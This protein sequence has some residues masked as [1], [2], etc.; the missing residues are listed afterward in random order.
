MATSNSYNFTVDRDDLITDALMYI[1]AIGEGEDPSSTQ[2]TECSRALNMIVK[3]READGMPLWALKRGIILP[4]TGVA[5]I[6]TQ[7]HIVQT[8]ART[9]IS[10]DEASGQTTL[11]ITDGT[12]ITNSDVIGI[13]LDDSTMHWTTVISGGGTSTI[14][15]A[16]ALTDDAASGNLVYAYTTTNRI[17]R[18]VRVLDA[19]ILTS[20]DTSTPIDVED[21]KDYFDLSSRLTAGTPN[22]IAYDAGLGD[23]TADPTASTWYGTF[24]IWPTFLG[25]DNVIEFTYQRPFQD[26]DAATDHP[27]FPQ[28]FYLPLMLELAYI[29]SGKYG[30]PEETRRRLASDAKT[31]REEALSTVTTEGSFSIQVDT[32][33]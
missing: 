9:T 17:P 31:Y 11:S 28:A 27:D 14:T 3:L 20:S 8:Y 33:P 24:Y 2:L 21:L 26:F 32:G 6:N 15:V 23:N 10:A 1:G 30:L 29:L 22:L 19:N 18:P 12:D 16:D 7:S 25:G 5:S 4:V 13:E